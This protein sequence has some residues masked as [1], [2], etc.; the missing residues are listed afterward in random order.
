MSEQANGRNAWWLSA[1]RSCRMRSLRKRWSHPG[2]R[3]T[4]QRHRPSLSRDSTP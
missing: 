2:V 4:T 3:S 1:R